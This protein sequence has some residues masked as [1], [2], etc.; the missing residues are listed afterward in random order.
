MFREIMVFVGVLAVAAGFSLAFLSQRYWFARVWR[1]AGRIRWLPWRYG[2]RATVLAVLAAI[3]FIAL[4]GIM[5]NLRGT[6]SRGSWATAFFGLW[7]TSSIFAYL[8]IKLVAGV[9]WSWRR[10]CSAFSNTTP[11][12]AA[13][14]AGAETIDYSRRYFFQTAGFLAGAVPFVSAAYGY[15][16]ERLRFE[17]HRVEIP[18][19]IFRR[20]SIPCA[21]CN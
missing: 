19:R 8:F 20:D 12:N 14:V 4:S 5:R 10:F 3:A 16:A 6:I 18:M 21:S 7:L 17:V 2:L 1:L 15:V 13:S 9:E 11:I